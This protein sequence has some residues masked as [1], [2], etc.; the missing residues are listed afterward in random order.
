MPL[1]LAPLPCHAVPVCPQPPYP[2]APCG[3]R[4]GGHLEKSASHTRF[5]R[6]QDISRLFQKD[7]W[8]FKVIQDITIW[9]MIFKDD[10]TY[11]KM[12]QDISRWFKICQYYFKRIRFF[13]LKLI[14]VFWVKW[15]HLCWQDTLSLLW[16]LY[17][18]RNQTAGGWKLF[19]R[20]QCLEF[21]RLNSQVCI[22][23]VE[24]AKRQKHAIRSLCLPFPVFLVLDFLFVTSAMLQD[25]TSI[26]RMMIQVCPNWI[27]TQSNTLVFFQTTNMTTIGFQWR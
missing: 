19:P 3:F 27:Q 25:I 16:V 20:L 22:P 10:S 8:Y 2:A 12:I 13:F 23:T 9:F 1:H 17:S 11:V 15:S 18:S 7:S 4:C 5:K 6:I 26:N 14:Q 24:P 21:P